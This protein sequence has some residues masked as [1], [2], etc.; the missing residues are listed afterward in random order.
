M[1]GTCEGCELC[2][3]C[4]LEGHESIAWC[5]LDD[6]FV[7]IDRPICKWVEDEFGKVLVVEGEAL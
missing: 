2:V 5:R 3:R 1:V 7:Y 4:D 6:N